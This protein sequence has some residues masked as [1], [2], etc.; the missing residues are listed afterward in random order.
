MASGPKKTTKANRFARLGFKLSFGYIFLAILISVAFSISVYISFSQQTLLDERDK[1][2]T[3][4]SI[5]AL[6]VD[7]QKVASLAQQPD[8][9][10][11]DLEPVVKTLLSINATN[12]DI[13]SVYLMTTDK[14]GQ[15]IFLADSAADDPAQPGQ[16][17][18]DP[19]DLLRQNI[20]SLSE[21][22]VENES[23][24]DEWG[25]WI[26]GYAPVLK[27]DGSLAAVIAIDISY[28]SVLAK[29]RHLAL[30]CLIIALGTLPL[31]IFIGML[32]ARSIT[33]PVT[34]L[35]ATAD[36]I[37]EKD[38]PQLKD[39]IHAMA[40]GRLGWQVKMDARPVELKTRDE[41]G[42]LGEHFNRIIELLH[43]TGAAYGKMNQNL[44]D[45]ISQL[46]GGAGQMND[47]STQLVDISQTS[48]R[49]TTKINAGMEHLSSGVASQVKAANEM[50]VIVDN[51]E[52]DIHEVSK[53]AQQQATAV[54]KAVGLTN[55]ISG[56]IE[57][58][59][60]QAAQSAQGSRESARVAQQGMEIVD[61]TI[62]GMDT[63][64]EHVNASTE[65]VREMGKRSAQIGVIVET[66][67]E[68]A[69]QT[70]LLALNAAIEAVRAGEHGSGF[71]VVAEEV[72]KLAEKSSSAAG[73][74][75]TLIR[76][77]TQSVTEAVDVME[78]GSKEAQ[79]GVQ[80]AH[81]AGVALKSILSAVE[82]EQVTTEAVGK[83]A[84]RVNQS[85]NEMVTATD[86][87][88]E[89]VDQNITVTRQM[90]DTA[91]KVMAAFHSIVEIS[92]QTERLT[93]EVVESTHTM[94]AQTELTGLSAQSLE[95]LAKELSQAANQFV[96]A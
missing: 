4:T 44:V 91:G 67:D 34:L 30:I 59:A 45:L 37:S 43:S 54:E 75:T 63:I 66:I 46:Q 65:K 21:T 10:N 90:T 82:T 56:A 25:T 1:L 51:L 33:R 62:R 6:T 94:A 42:E 49:V 9:A 48:D 7:S 93:G 57:E 58:I 53:G 24:T 13:A 89:V 2:G 64:A 86:T 77:I 17:Y 3:M 28:S 85:V 29:Q 16:S 22:M 79:T 78:A 92:E 20:A 38:L 96:V 60:R 35:A 80:L 23:Y 68:I 61:H 83:A 41:I 84:V 71:A 26:S 47:A 40:D 18:D 15:I 73:E 70:N 55:Q 27:K 31:A 8:K 12:P 81:Q 5:A 95:T 14:T 88:N 74:I 87:V 11:P 50:L 72:R 19:S 76:D 36:Q 52:R 32:M 39:A 69:S